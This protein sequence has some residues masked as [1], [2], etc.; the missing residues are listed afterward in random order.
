MDNYLETKRGIEPGSL[1]RNRILRL[2]VRE[3][4]F[5]PECVEL[6]EKIAKFELNLEKYENGGFT[7]E[8]KQEWDDWALE[9]NFGIPADTAYFIKKVITHLNKQ[10]FN[11]KYTKNRVAQKLEDYIRLTEKIDLEIPLENLP[12]HPFYNYLKV[13]IRDSQVILIYAKGPR[14][15]EIY[16]QYEKFLDEELFRQNALQKLDEIDKMWGIIKRGVEKI[17]MKKFFTER[18]DFTQTFLVHI[19][20]KIKEIIFQ[21]DIEKYLILAQNK[22]ELYQNISE[23][24]VNDKSKGSIPTNF[25][26][27][28]VIQVLGSINEED[29]IVI[30]R[31]FMTAYEEDSFFTADKA[32]L[33]YPTQVDFINPEVLTHGTNSNAF[34]GFLEMS[35]ICSSRLLVKSGIPKT[36]SGEN[37]RKINGCSD[38]AVS[39]CLKE[40]YQEEYNAMGG[41]GKVP[42]PSYPMLFVVEYENLQKLKLSKGFMASVIEVTAPDFVPLEFINQVFVPHF[43]VQEVRNILEFNGYKNI[44]VNSF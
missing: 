29:L 25:L 26:T 30:L 39:F 4:H 15:G 9:K 19:T 1:D 42:S 23:I 28:K 20:Y 40:P 2:R 37:F 11:Q 14:E 5:D 16:Y 21:K 12:N 24:I 44:Q 3:P 13:L 10:L 38:S 8:K 35:G 22:D 41:W 6:Q 18:S 34:H 31:G 33:E 36:G 43:K 17:G 7:K 32:N 27:K